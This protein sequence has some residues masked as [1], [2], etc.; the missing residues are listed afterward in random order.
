MRERNRLLS[1]LLLLLVSVAAGRSTA[2]SPKGGSIVIAYSDYSYQGVPSTAPLLLAASVRK[3]GGSLRD[4]PIR[5]YAS[6]AKPLSEELRKKAAELR[7]EIRSYRPEPALSA[8]PFAMKALAAAQAEEEASADCLVWFDRDSLVLG[9]IAEL[10]LPPGKALG[11]RPVNGR[12]IGDLAAAPLDAF[13]SRAYALGGLD[14]A[15]AGR[16]K[17]YMGGEELHFYIAAGLLAVR[18]ERGVLRDWAELC[19]RFAE[20][21][22][23]AREAQKSAARRIFMHQAA[24]SVAAARIPEAERLEFAEDLMYPLNFYESDPEGRRP[25]RIDAVRSLR[26]DTSLEDPGWQDFPMS[27]EFKTWLLANIR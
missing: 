24:L 19:R 15:R 18:P 16:T 7:V 23:L 27:E 2:E 21:P 26:Y 13:W 9:D 22:E 5:Y 4:A 20:D 1:N 17:T 14:P 8:W 12:N 25:P 10:A 3:Y 6:S 11:Y